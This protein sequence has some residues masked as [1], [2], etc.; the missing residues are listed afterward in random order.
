M[1]ILE[2]NQC[3]LVTGAS[4]A[5]DPAYAGASS[6]AS[7]HGNKLGGSSNLFGPSNGVVQVVAAHPEIA[8]CLNGILGGMV[9]GSA[10]GPGS[11]V[12]SAIGGGIG[13]CFNNSGNSNAGNSFG[14]QCTW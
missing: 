11:A 4:G 9:G 13:S 3:L 2:N 14:S 1:K 5:Y 10:G 7:Q 6:Y 12:A 8:G